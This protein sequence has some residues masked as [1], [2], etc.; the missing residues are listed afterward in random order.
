MSITAT[1]FYK[2][3]RTPGHPAPPFA[4]PS[5]T[6]EHMGLVLGGVSTADLLPEE[7]IELQASYPF[8]QSEIRRLYRRFRK[9]DVNKTGGITRAQLLKIPELSMNPL[10]QRIISLFH[11][12]PPLAAL[13]A[14]S[15]AT[16]STV[17]S[18]ARAA[19]R[20]ARRGRCSTHSTAHIRCKS[21]RQS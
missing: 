21:E 8:T 14:S 16:A 12:P 11:P 9:L 19:E 4:T 1:K 3:V 6:Q 7:I 2:P 20:T 17:A 15:V 13:T 5:P 10:A 18:S